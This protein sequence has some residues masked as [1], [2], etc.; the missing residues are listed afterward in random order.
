MEDMTLAVFFC[1]QIFTHE[2]KLYNRSN[3]ALHRR[4]GDPDDT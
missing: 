4:K 3:L 1:P 2:R